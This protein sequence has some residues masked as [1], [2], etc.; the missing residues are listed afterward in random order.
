[1]NEKLVSVISS[2]NQTLTVSVLSNSYTSTMAMN[3]KVKVW[4]SK[5][6]VN[7]SESSE[8]QGPVLYACEDAIV[9]QSER[10]LYSFDMKTREFGR[11]RS[12]VDH[13]I[14]IIGYVNSLVE[15]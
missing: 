1:M 2:Y 10:G 7:V 14:R 8:Y 11:L 9:I 12:E 4:D 5:L 13:D 15:I 3:S 6:S